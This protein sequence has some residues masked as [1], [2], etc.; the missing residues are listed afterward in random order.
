M[1]N[2][3][4]FKSRSDH[5]VYPM[6][7]VNRSASSEPRSSGSDT[8]SLNQSHELHGEDS[9]MAKADTSEGSQNFSDWGDS[10]LDEIIENTDSQTNSTRDMQHGSISAGNCQCGPEIPLCICGTNTWANQESPTAP[11]LT[12][13][14]NV[15]VAAWRQTQGMKTPGTPGTDDE[16]NY[17]LKTPTKED[18]A[19]YMSPKRHREEDDSGIT[20]KFRRALPLN[21]VTSADVSPMRRRLDASLNLNQNAKT[22]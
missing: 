8:L 6:R 3:P 18:S 11:P 17:A 14:N 15:N 4:N 2:S 22:G 16:N 7:S 12:P 9:L 5:T 13:E 19:I 10:M 1:P 20:P 21:V